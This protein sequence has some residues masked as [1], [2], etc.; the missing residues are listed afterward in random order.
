VTASGAAATIA[1]G[2]QYSVVTLDVDA[3]GVSGVLAAPTGVTLD[4][5]G[6]PEAADVAACAAPG[7]WRF[8]AATEH[9]EVRVFAPMGQTRAVAIQ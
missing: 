5:A 8:D 2:A 1:G 3:R 7:C 4:G 6:L 9:L